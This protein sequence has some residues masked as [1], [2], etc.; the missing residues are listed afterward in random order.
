MKHRDNLKEGTTAFIF[1]NSLASV[2]RHG[3]EQKFEVIMLQLCAKYAK[4]LYAH[5]VVVSNGV[6]NQF[7][8]TPAFG[9]WRK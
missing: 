3:I 5:V 9:A 2:V 8:K 6:T 4:V 7:S 1:T